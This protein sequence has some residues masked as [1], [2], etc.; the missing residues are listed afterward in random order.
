MVSSFCLARAPC[1]RLPE[2]TDWDVTDRDV[3]CK[4]LASPFLA[5]CGSHRRR[6]PLLTFTRAPPLCLLSIRSC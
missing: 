2:Y 5:T 3:A 6:Q 1:L 4:P